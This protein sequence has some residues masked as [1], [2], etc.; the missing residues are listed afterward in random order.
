M[1]TSSSCSATEE[2][3]SMRSGSGDEFDVIFSPAGA[4]IRGF[5]HESAMSPYVDDEPWPGV[6]DS[7]PEVF[8]RYVEDYY[9]IQV[10]LD[11]VR[12]VYA[13]RPLTQE[14]VAALNSKVAWAE[15]SDAAT[16]IGYAVAV[17][18]AS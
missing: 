16:A 5:D 9:E 18:A 7:V 1:R 11:A 4:Y 2:V 6:V 3:A 15:I 13:L 10:D 17:G 8:R 14:V 12:H